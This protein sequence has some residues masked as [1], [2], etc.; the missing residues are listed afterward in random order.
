MTRPLYDTSAKVDL[1]LRALIDEHE[2]SDRRW[3]NMRPLVLGRV[4]LLHVRLDML[5]RDEEE[6]E[7][8]PAGEEAP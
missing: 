3:D 8:L 5:L 1:A 7:A 6:R 2:V 4:R